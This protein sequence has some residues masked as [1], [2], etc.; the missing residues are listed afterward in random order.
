MKNIKKSLKERELK[1][2]YTKKSEESEINFPQNI[3]IIKKVRKV[4]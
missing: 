2:Y 1:K 3:S 4:S